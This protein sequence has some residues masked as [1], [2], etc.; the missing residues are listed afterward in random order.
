MVLS[1]LTATAAEKPMNEENAMNWISRFTLKEP[2]YGAVVID[3]AT[4]T[5][6]PTFSVTP[7][8]SG[9][10][11]VRV[12]LPF[13]RGSFP[14]DLGLGV[15]VDD[16]EISPDVRVLTYHPGN[17]EFVRRALVT[18]IHTFEDKSPR[19]FQVCLKAEG[20]DLHLK[21]LPTES[22]AVALVKEDAQDTP[23]PRFARPLPEGE[24]R[25]RVDSVNKA[26]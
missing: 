11:L 5:E 23:H 25:V 8:E 1:S 12:S 4:S 13:P 9:L 14:S 21:E 26:G 24:G 6:L 22:S 16:E 19:N 18:F 17:K 20:S 7:K 15:K 2:I 3:A 10:Q